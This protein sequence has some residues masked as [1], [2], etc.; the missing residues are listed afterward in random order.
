M[1]HSKCICFNCSNGEKC[2]DFLVETAAYRT[3]AIDL[4]VQDFGGLGGLVQKA[5][6]STT[7]RIPVLKLTVSCHKVVMDG[8]SIPPVAPLCEVP[9]H[10]SLVSR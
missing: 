10:A 4:H 9:S 3:S 1:A 7:N 8:V 5:A 6:V 2:F